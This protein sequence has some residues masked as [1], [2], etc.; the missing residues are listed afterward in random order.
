MMLAFLFLCQQAI[1]LS[2]DS[3]VLPDGSLREGVKVVVVE[4]RIVEVSS[5]PETNGLEVKLDG[6]LAPGFVD[7][8]SGSYGDELP[9]TEQSDVVTPDLNAVDGVQFDSDVWRQL[10]AHGVT[11]VH[12]MPDPTNVISGRAALLSTSSLNGLSTVLEDNTVQVASLLSSLVSDSRVGPSSLAGALEVLDQSVYDYGA[13]ALGVR[14]W[15]YVEDAAGVRGVQ[16]ILKRFGIQ[17]GRFILNGDPGSYAAL[18]QGQ[19]VGV[20]VLTMDSL[21][22]KA[23]VWRRMAKNQIRV[24]FGSQMADADWNALRSSAMAFSRI[25]GKPEHAFASITSYS[26]EM[27][28]RTDIGAIKAGARADLVLWTSHPLN[29]EAKVLSTMIGGQTVYRAELIH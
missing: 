29:A 4:D 2:P 17:D 5:A 25:T 18:F 28:G 26:A 10:C 19:L 6:V 3:V 15:F 7:A 16:K 23:E 22:R 8:F 24:A 27:L 13:R 14:P 11:T 12:F 1:I 21:A 20:S 9:L